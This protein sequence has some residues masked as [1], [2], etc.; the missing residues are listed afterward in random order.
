MTP[1]QPDAIPDALVAIGLATVVT[2]AFG[3]VTRMNAVAEALTGWPQA[4]AEGRPL[5]GVFHTEDEATRRPA[6]PAVADVLVTGVAVGLSD[7]TVLVARGGRERRIDHGAA[8][9]RD[10]AGAVAGS[11]VVFCDVGERVRALRGVEEAGAFAQ[12]IVRQSV[13]RSPVPSVRRG[14]EER[15]GWG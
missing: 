6:T 8:P 7:H 2:D 15:D 1:N 4:E 3:R 11:V 9:V 12:G 10:A 14:Q 13:G 5:G